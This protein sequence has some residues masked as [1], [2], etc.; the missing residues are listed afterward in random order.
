MSPVVFWPA[1][2]MAIC[3][4]SLLSTEPPHNL[5]Q[6]SGAVLAWI[7]TFGL[8]WNRW[9][10]R[11]SGLLWR[12]AA[13]AAAVILMALIH[14]WLARTDVFVIY[15]SNCPPRMGSFWPL[16][17]VWIS[18][19]GLQT[20]AAWGLRFR[21]K[22]FLFTPTFRSA[23][24]WLVSVVWTLACGTVFTR[25]INAVA[26]VVS[27]TSLAK[28]LG[29]LVAVAAV[30]MLFLWLPS[31]SEAAARKKA[32]ADYDAISPANRLAMLS[33]IDSA[34]RT[35]AFRLMYRAASGKEVADSLARI[36]GHPL[37]GSDEAWPT[38]EGVPG[39]FLLQVALA[40]VSGAA[41]ANRLIA[42]YLMQ[43]SLRV[44]SY[45]CASDLVV[46]TAPANAAQIAMQPLKSLALPVALP[47]YRDGDEPLGGDALIERTP[48]L[49]D[50]LAKL[51]T[52]P[53][54]VV[55]L[56]ISGGAS[57]TVETE[58]AILVGGKPVLLQGPHEPHCDVC[59]QPMRFLLQF[60]DV[61]QDAQLGDGGV[62]YV[63]GCDAHPAHCQGF[64]DC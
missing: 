32:L 38:V 27:L 40:D 49:G 47:A 50:M 18:G 54:R 56:L 45:A 5:A 41:W 1:F 61:T 30:G 24:W 21:Y 19:I 6:V 33:V 62:G 57:G 58:D 64:A 52:Q 25:N 53:A 15:R 59:Q 60:G 42:V 43:E 8:A 51:T 29:V 55:S 22:N 46:K 3:I 31:R 17:F 4:S 7:V 20:F 48:G 26:L 11:S 39:Q 9:S 35:G 37:A 10:G 36:G 14:D 23:A 44:K 16:F 28:L 12:L 34:A 2:F 63:Y 13:V